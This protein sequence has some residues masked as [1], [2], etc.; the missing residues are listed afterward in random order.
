MRHFARVQKWAC[1]R[2]VH[3]TP[4]LRGRC[5]FNWAARWFRPRRR[6]AARTRGFDCICNDG[7]TDDA[8]ACVDIEEC[9]AGTDDF[10]DSRL[11][12]NVVGSFLCVCPDG[13][14]DC[15]VV[16]GDGLVG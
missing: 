12:E 11:C 16:C 9:T 15:R 1:A 8:G 4:R 7:F 13:E 10:N 6:P 2:T 5:Y 14:T 3:G